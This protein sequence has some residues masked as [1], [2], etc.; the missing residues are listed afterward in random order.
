MTTLEKLRRAERWRIKGGVGFNGDFL[1]PMNG[2]L[3]LVRLSEDDRWRHLSI[4]NMQRKV[5]PAWAIMRWA[6]DTFFSDEDW[7]VQYFPPRSEYIYERQWALDIW[8][9]TEEK[10]PI[11]H[12]DLV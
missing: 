6:R 11:P 3:W 4:S 9:P 1:V 7:C 5:V 8:Q 2:E 12:L 10:L